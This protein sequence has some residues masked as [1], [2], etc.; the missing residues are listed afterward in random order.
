M[1]SFLLKHSLYECTCTAVYLPTMSVTKT[2]QHRN[3]WIMVNSILQ[4]MWKETILVLF[5][6]LPQN[7]PGQTERNHE[8]PQ[9]V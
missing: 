3:A 6:I 4:I 7:L 1:F 8:N 2:V 5:G 9:S